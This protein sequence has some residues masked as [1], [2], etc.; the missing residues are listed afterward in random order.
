MFQRYFYN[1]A[2]PGTVPY[3]GPGPGE[4]EAKWE[5]A[6][7]KKPAEDLM[8]T[9]CK[10]F[11]AMGHRLRTQVRQ[12]DILQIRLHEINKSLT[13]S[14]QKHDLDITVRTS[15]AKRKHIV[16]SHRCLNL[17]T[18]IQV[19]KSR[20][21]SLD[22]PEER[23]KSKL[24]ELEKAAFDPR[25]HG[26]SDEIWARME[27]LRQRTEALHA[28]ME[29]LGKNGGNNS[30]EAIDEDVLKKTKKVCLL[31]CWPVHLYRPRVFLTDDHQILGN[32]DSQITHLGR[33]LDATKKDFRA[34]ETD[35]GQA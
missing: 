34:W 23:L 12:V 4:D 17:A 22:G 20:G 25:F 31:S 14:L 30:G 13:E 24:Q 15:E 9:L 7:S 8:P 29:K 11:A 10:G 2:A 16:L 1:I 35:A 26:R 6:L 21:Y 18:K 32:Y 5:E 3:Y 27:G 33:E 28:E 19:L